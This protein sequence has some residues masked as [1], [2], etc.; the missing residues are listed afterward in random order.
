MTR[1]RLAALWAVLPAAVFVYAL[2]L[3][4][5]AEQGGLMV[6]WEWLPSLGIDLA[7]RLDGLALLFV[8]LI[9]GIGALV[10]VY[11]TAY[12]SGHPQRG[13]FLG[14]LLAFMVSMLG[15]VL[16]DHLITLFVFW[17]LTS[18]TSFLLIGF[19]HDKAESRRA[20]RQALLVTGLGG[21]ALL[22]GVLLLG[23]VAGSQRLSELPA[24]ATSIQ[25]HPLYGAIFALMA[26]GALTK[27]AQFPFHF[28]LPNAMAAPTPVSAF[29]HS[30]TMVKAGIFLLMRL[31]PVL[32]GTAAWTLTLSTVGGITMLLGAVWALK[33]TDLK[34]IL[35]YSTLTA[36]GTLTLLIG[37][38]FELSIKAAVVF[39]VVHAL[40]KAALFLIAGSVEHATGTRDLRQLGAAVRRGMPL[41]F[42]AAALA[43]LS[44][45][46]V[47]PLFG[48]IGKELTYEAKLGFAGADILLIVAAVLANAL[49]ITAA[50]IV[51]LGAF[52]KREGAPPNEPR[53]VSTA[54]LLGP[55]VLAA[56]GLLL[57]AHPDL[58]EALL[59]LAAT[60]IAGHPVQVELALWHGATPALLLSGLTLATGVV[61]YLARAPLR[62]GLER[63]D[64]GFGDAAYDA[65]LR[66]L[67]ALATTTARIV[68]SAKLRH[69]L[70][71]VV[72]MAAGLAAYPLL[73]GA[74]TTSLPSLTG[75]QIAAEP[76][77]MVSITLALAAVVAGVV[78][79]RGQGRLALLTA[80]GVMGFA[81]A[82]LFLTLGAPDLAITQLLVETLVVVV[83]VLVLRR[84][85]GIV[86]ES[87]LSTWT[88]GVN[89][90][91][92]L[93][94]A[95]VVVFIAWSAAGLDVSHDAAAYFSERSVTEGHGRNIVN[96]ILVDFR[97]LDTLGEVVVVATAGMGIFA[98]SRRALRTAGDGRSA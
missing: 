1:P 47:P 49:T 4:G 70:L 67:N 54:M 39:V 61:A 23:E 46:G 17:E 31:D 66:G 36:L 50:A 80:L 48:F 75:L 73:T 2:S 90:I 9:S 93:A 14:F 38:S 94:V 72:A 81:V 30:A 42:G 6:T 3:V 68:E 87:D 15:L 76:A 8:L 16:A 56:L 13:R 84:S 29:L 55:L 74:L 78:A 57:G 34:S 79:A 45:A 24:L 69:H 22:A 40:Y 59:A 32:G 12:M 62:R 92:A 96:V 41:T 21:L 85:Q 83:A 89:A 91:A 97:A 10:V 26:I 18:L 5:A 71:L 33:H 86:R 58:P 25:E 51:V 19:K 63:L 44:M 20:A 53:E 65:A 11:A 77:G 35:A 43:G 98:L 7:F 82:L 37:L 28:W 52:G 88:K 60:A 95:A 27:S 64:R